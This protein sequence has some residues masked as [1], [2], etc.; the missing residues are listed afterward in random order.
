MDCISG[1]DIYA[2]G[3]SQ[4]VDIGCS[5]GIGGNLVGITDQDIIREMKKW[6]GIKHPSL[7]DKWKG[8]LG[9]VCAVLITNSNEF[10][11][12]LIPA[13]IMVESVPGRRLQVKWPINPQDTSEEVPVECD[14][15]IDGGGDVGGSYPIV[16]ESA[17]DPSKSGDGTEPHVDAAMDKVV[18][19]FERWHYEGGYRRLRVFSGI[20]PV[21]T[22]EESF[23]AC[24]EAAIQHS[25]EWSCPEHI[26]K[27]RIVESLRGPAMGIIHP[28]KRSNPNATLKDSVDAL[29][30]S[31]ETLE[32][33]GDILP[34][35]NH[36][37]QG[38]NESY[39][40]YL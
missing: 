8:N 24:R 7:S 21:P 40:I 38:Q 11:P 35:L 27:Q 28:T 5:V 26:K 34:R 36:T 20:I 4:G 39:Y 19:H 17:I 32:D 18:S 29:D 16:G 23:D 31:F 10:D 9:Y 12:S 33:I 14:S 13:N 6:Y 25:E 15:Q 2:W 22:G 37:F 30:Y 1:D 3:K